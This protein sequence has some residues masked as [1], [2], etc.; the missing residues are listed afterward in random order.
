MSETAEAVCRWC[1][2]AMT[3]T[4]DHV[5]TVRN[6]DWICPPCWKGRLDYQPPSAAAEPSAP[7]EQE[8]EG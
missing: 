4:V 8:A 5:T 6:T 1:G 2:V 3:V 7:A